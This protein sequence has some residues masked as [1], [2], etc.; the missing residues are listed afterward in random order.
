MALPGL[1]QEAM[2]TP[3]FKVANRVYSRVIKEMTPAHPVPVPHPFP[4]KPRQRAVTARPAERKQKWDT[5]THLK[6]GIWPLK[7][8][9]KT[10]TSLRDENHRELL[11]K[12]V[13]ARTLYDA[14]FQVICPHVTPHTLCPAYVKPFW[15]RICSELVGPAEETLLASERDFESASAPTRT[16]SLGFLSSYA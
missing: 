16:S 13:M 10:I 5:S 4:F 1:Q 2:A 14:Q 7:E 8:G 6:D 9:K 15:R 11:S 12:S 3:Q